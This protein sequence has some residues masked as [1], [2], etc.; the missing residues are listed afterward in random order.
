MNIAD[1]IIVLADGRVVNDGPRKD[2]LPTLLGG[3]P[4][5]CSALTDKVK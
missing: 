2:V 1:R 5:V 3:A 4:G